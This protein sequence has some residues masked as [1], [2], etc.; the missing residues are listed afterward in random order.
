MLYFYDIEED[1]IVKFPHR[2]YPVTSINLKPGANEKTICIAS[3]LTIF[4]Y[5]RM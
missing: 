3:D 1:D 4:F 2:K 5:S